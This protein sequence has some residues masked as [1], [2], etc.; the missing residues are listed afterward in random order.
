[1]IEVGIGSSDVAFDARIGHLLV[2]SS[3]N[4]LAESTFWIGDGPFDDDL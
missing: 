4:S 2:V 1:M 3:T